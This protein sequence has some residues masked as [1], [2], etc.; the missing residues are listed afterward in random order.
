M[1]STPF[2]SNTVRPDPCKHNTHGPI[3]PLHMVLV[4]SSGITQP[5]DTDGENKELIVKFLCL[6]CMSGPAV[7]AKGMYRSS[8]DFPV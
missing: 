1:S 2:F 5:V 4:C 6:E 7:Q 3:H 8:L